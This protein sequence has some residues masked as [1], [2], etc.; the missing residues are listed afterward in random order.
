MFDIIKEAQLKQEQTAPTV[1][2]RFK[3]KKQLKE[4]KKEQRIKAREHLK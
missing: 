2:P 3:N 4:F 1:F